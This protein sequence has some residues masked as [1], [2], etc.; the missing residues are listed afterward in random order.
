V[1]AVAPADGSAPSLYPFDA[2]RFEP[3][4]EWLAAF[5]GGRRRGGLPST[6]HV[7]HSARS[8]IADS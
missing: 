1:I 2:P 6:S 8:L 7:H 3:V 4:A 5:Q